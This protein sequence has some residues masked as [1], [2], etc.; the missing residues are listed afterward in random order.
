MKY[1]SGL[2]LFITSCIFFPLLG[3]AQPK[4]TKKMLTR[5]TSAPK[6]EVSAVRAL[7]RMKGGKPLKAQVGA[8]L[9]QKIHKQRPTRQELQQG[10]IFQAV[11]PRDERFKFSGVVFYTYYNGKKEIYGAMVAHAISSTS[12]YPGIPR[13]FEATFFLPNNQTKKIP[14]EIVAFSPVNILDLV[15][16]KFPAQAEAFL[17]PFPLGNLENEK[18]V[19]SLGYNDKGFLPIYNRRVIKELPY[20][21][22][23]TMP[24]ADRT[25]RQGLCGSA[26]LNSQNQLVGIHTG[27]ALT[28]GAQNQLPS[29]SF[30]TPSHFLNRLVEAYHNGGQATVPFYIDEERFI[31]LPINEYIVSY[32]LLNA[33]GR[34]LKTREVNLHLSRTHLK[35]QLQALPQAKF[36]LITTH[37]L[38]WDSNNRALP[39]LSFFD[40]DVPKTT[41]LYNLRTGKQY[42]LPAFIHPPKPRRPY[43]F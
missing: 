1:T 32:S 24:I 16:V 10:R 11:F 5:F 41:Y 9:A 17:N 21:L 42:K 34:P 30:A 31:N 26:V 12:L 2:F 35:E 20:S 13:H 22:R 37:P 18:K 28:L 23:T 36:L 25:L 15:L 4:M 27:S 3:Y 40:E 43:G 19:F 33:L 14:A 7:G 39:M 6:A 38:S 29:C 8:V